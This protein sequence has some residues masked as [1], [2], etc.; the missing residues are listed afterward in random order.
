MI[1]HD[2]KIKQIYLARIMEGSKT[3]EIRDND[4]DYQVG[5]MLVFHPVI[6]EKVG[7]AYGRDSIEGIGH[8]I[9]TYL[10]AFCLQEG[11]V[12]LSIRECTKDER[13]RAYHVQQET[14]K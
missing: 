6:E 13:D 7:A 8:Y 3:F 1:H 4:R 2:I 5:D 9:I 11:F 14:T 10:T 12:C